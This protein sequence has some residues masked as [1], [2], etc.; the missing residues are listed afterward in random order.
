[1]LI[2]TYLLTL[3][4]G[5]FQ[6]KQ[7]LLPLDNK[8]ALKRSFLFAPG[9]LAPLPNELM[10]SN[11]VGGGYITVVVNLLNPLSNP[12][13]RS[14][15]PVP[16]PAGESEPWLSSSPLLL[17][18]LSESADCRFSTVILQNFGLAWTTDYTRGTPSVNV[19]TLL[20]GLSSSSKALASTSFQF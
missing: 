12:A 18:L 9:L 2:R 11:F 4:F 15:C 7:Y 13:S 3:L 5:A 16:I 8:V 17:L 19:S 10:P 14:S 20:R 1:M 6:E